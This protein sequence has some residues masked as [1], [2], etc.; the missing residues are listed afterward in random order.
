MME[1]PERFEKAL[2]YCID[3]FFS[4]WPQ[5]SPGRDKLKACKIVSHRGEHDNLT[6]F[7]NTIE[8]F[9]LAFERGIW[10][11]EFDVRWTKDLQPVVN[12]D[13]DLQRIF[14][15]DLNIADVTLDELKS[16]C[17]SVPLLSEVVEKYAKKLHF[18]IEIKAEAYPDPFPV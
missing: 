7:E 14:G 8:A 15:L 2:V 12:H 10:G 11:I 6:V 1:L 4:F 16:T 9:D 13:P 5:P 3:L 17:P 18:M